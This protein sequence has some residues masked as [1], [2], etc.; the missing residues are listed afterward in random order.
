MSD[1]PLLSRIQDRVLHLTLNRPDKRNALSLEL[2]TRISA[3]LGAATTNPGVGAAVLSAAGDH[4]C[5]GFDLKELMAAPDPAVVF[6]EANAYHR[7]VHNFPKPLV[8]A[9]SG[10]AL[11]GGFDLALLCDIRLAAPDA[12]FGQPQ[13]RHGM[14]ALYDLV[15]KAVG[16]SRA[17]ELCL[18]GRIV[19][20]VEAEHIG[21][22][23]RIVDRGQ[24]V[25]QALALAADLAAV[26]S[27]ALAKRNFITSQPDLFGID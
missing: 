8:A 27:S 2:R 17:R 23:H 7:T 15:A 22:V 3:E 20:A 21:L 24:L 1:T 12:S 9:V 10:S 13:V 6:N 5:A 4:F 11:A 18:T 25:E 19:D 14:P 26:P 16:D